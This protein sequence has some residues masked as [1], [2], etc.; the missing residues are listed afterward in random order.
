MLTLE[1]KLSDTFDV[2]ILNYSSIEEMIIAWDGEVFITSG[3]IGEERCYVVFERD[4]KE[5]ALSYISHK[6][7][8]K[9]RPKIQDLIPPPPSSN[10][11]AINEYDR[12]IDLLVRP[13]FDEDLCV[14]TISLSDAIDLALAHTLKNYGYGSFSR[15]GIE[16]ALEQDLP[17][18]DYIFVEYTVYCKQADIIEVSNFAVDLRTEL[19]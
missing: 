2:S 13:K 6:E 10:M 4:Q 18:N 14:E 1:E 8:I 3:D 16:R 15:V 7:I 17:H 5:I 12:I 11:N 19:Q 9:A